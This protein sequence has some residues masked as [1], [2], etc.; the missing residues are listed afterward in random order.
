M[1]QSW[2]YNPQETDW[3]AP[4]K[5]VR[6]L[7]E[8][9][10]RGGNYLLN[11]GPTERGTFPPEAMERLQYIGQWMQKNSETIYG[12]TYTP[13]QGAE[14]G[15]AT[16]KDGL[17]YLHV[18]DWPS[19]GKLEISV[20]PVTASKV[21]LQSGVPV[22]FVQNGGQLELTLPTHAPDADVSVV[23][24]EFSDTNK[25]LVSYSPEKET[26]TSTLQYIKKQAIANG[27]INSVLNGLIAFFTYRLRG[28]IPYAE[29]A[30]DILITVFIIA[31]LISWLSIGSTRTEIIKG[32]L[33]AP[34]KGW[35]GLKLPRGAG[36][37]ALLITLVCVIVF[38]GL[39]MDGLL[40]LLAPGGFNNWVYFVIKTLYT[41]LCA[42]LASSLTIQSVVRTKRV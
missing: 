23:V 42:A 1:G 10:S 5:L 37:S 25:A 13:L 31:Y 30:I 41:G 8:V 14:W 6:N 15:R 39:F 22:T 40:Y 27:W 4:G 28:P 16:I 29:A 26:R 7:I 21:S 33:P 12:C 34:V 3:K 32:N 20:F 18:F 2:G 19:A 36:L 17:I 38:G 9:V 11:V 24:V 35:P